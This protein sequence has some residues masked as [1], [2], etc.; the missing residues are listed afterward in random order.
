VFNG[1]LETLKIT[2]ILPNPVNKIQDEFDEVFT[3]FIA[4][5]EKA[6]ATGKDNS[7]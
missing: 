2:R 1:P 5:L 7:W 6:A 3:A 4:A